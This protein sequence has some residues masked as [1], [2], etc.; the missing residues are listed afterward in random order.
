MNSKRSIAA[1]IA[2]M[3]LGMLVLIAG[4]KSLLVVVP[5]AVLVWYGAAPKVRSGRN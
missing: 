1:M 2:F 4:Q 5:A 3:L